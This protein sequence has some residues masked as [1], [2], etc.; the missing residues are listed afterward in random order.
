M[1]ERQAAA[2]AAGAGSSSHS[3]AEPEASPSG[4]GRETVEG[5]ET[6]VEMEQN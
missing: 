2:Q 3:Q 5:E 4:L 1:L 6:A